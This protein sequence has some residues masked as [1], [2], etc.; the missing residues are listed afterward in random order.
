MLELFFFYYLNNRK[1]S[2]IVILL[3]KVDVKKCVFNLGVFL[4]DG[5]HDF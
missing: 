3:Y 5:L 4:K 1:E 2:K